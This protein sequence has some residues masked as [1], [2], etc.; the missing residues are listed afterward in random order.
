MGL[1]TLYVLCDDFLKEYQL[2][3]EAEGVVYVELLPK[4]ENRTS[5][6]LPVEA[7]FGKWIIRSRSDLGLKVNGR[8]V[9][10]Q[11]LAGQDVVTVVLP[12]GKVVLYVEQGNNGALSFQKFD[13]SNAQQISIGA[14]ER[15]TIVYNPP[16]ISS[17]HAVMKIDSGKASISVPDHQNLLYVNGI[18]TQSAA[19]NFGDM[20]CIMGLKIVYLGF[21]LA[22]NTPHGFEKCRLDPYD[23]TNAQKHMDEQSSRFGIMDDTYFQ[24]SPRIIKRLEEGEVEI[25]SPPSPNTHKEQPFLLTIGPAMTMGMVSVFSVMFAFYTSKGNPQMVIPGLVMAGAMLTGA[26]VWPFLSRAYQKMTSKKEEKRRVKKYRQYIEKEYAKLEERIER[27]KKALSSTYPE[28][29]VCINRALNKDRR[30]WE[31]MPS[32]K[33]FLEMRLGKGVR[34]SSINVIIPREH[35]SMVD[36]PLIDELKNINNG[37]LTV[38]NVPICISMLENSMIGMIG[39]R[40]ILLDLVMSMLVQIAALHSYDEVKVV[41]IYKQSESST[42]EWVKQL[43]HVWGPD[44]AIRFTASCRDEAREVLLYLNEILKEREGTKGDLSSSPVLS[45]PHFI[46]FIADPE[47]VENEPVMRYLTSSNGVLGVSTVFVYEKINLLPKE[48]NAF[49]QC[50][51]SE[52]SLYHRDNPEGGMIVFKEDSVVGQDLDAFS[53]ALAGIK[54]KEIASAL[55]LP[56]M[57]TFLGMYKVGRIEHLEIKRRWRENMSYRSLEAPLGIKAGDMTFYLNIHEKYHGP[58]GLVAGMTGSGKSEFIQSYILS[59]AVN[60]H[61]YDVA[62]ILIDYKGGGMANCFEGLPHVAGTITN[63][64]GSQIRRSLVSLESELKRRQRI[65]AEHGVNHIDKYQQLYKEHKAEEPLPHL[66]II[67]DE[68]AELK[69]QQ[70]EFMQELVSAARIG[71]SLGVHLVLATQKPSGVVDDQ[72]WSNTRFRICLKVLDKNDSNEMIK[73][74]DAANIIQAGRCYVQVGNDE[75]FELVQS[76]WSGA[77]YV[78]TDKVENESAKQVMLIDGCARALKTVSCKSAVSKSEVSELSA[79][80]NY[81]SELARKDSIKTL[82]LWLE[83]L[84]ETIYLDEVENRKGGWNGNDWEESDHWLCPTLG[85]LDNPKNQTQFPLVINIGNDGHIAL[86]GAPGTGKTTFIQTLVYSLVTRYSPE[87]VN[88]YI[89]DF[90]GRTMGYFHELPHVGGIVFSDDAD[91]MDKLFKL[92]TKELENRKKMFAEYGVGTLKSYMEATGNKLPAMVMILDNYAAFNEL[93]PDYESLIVTLSREA[94]NYGI[95]MVL[96]GSNSN[97]IKYRVTQNFKLIFTLQLN[98]KYDYVTVVGQTNGLEPESVPGRGLIKV[99]TPLEFQTALACHAANEAERF[100]ELRKLF[101]E[102]NEKWKGHKAKQIPFIPNEVTRESMMG[103]DEVKQE[104]EKGLIPIGYDINE[105]EML[106]LDLQSNFV[107]SVLGSEQTGKTNFI[108]L[109][110]GFIKPTLDWKVYVI[111][112]P[113][114]ELQRVSLRMGADGYICDAEGFDGFITGLVD[115]MKMRHKDLKAFRENGVNPS[116]EYEYMQKY[117]SIVVLIDEFDSFYDMIS[118]EA[119]KYTESLLK[120]GS[121][122]EVSFIFT[123]N[124]QKI[125]RF[126]GSVLYTQVFKGLNGILLGGMM[127]SQNIFNVTMNYQ[128]RSERLDTGMG[129][130]INRNTYKTIKTPLA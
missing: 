111:D 25:D 4:T 45:L 31:R 89:L 129:Y 52:C 83:P 87:L 122:L 26:I 118:D 61:P 21:L 3:Q 41:C 120:G 99:G 116:K 105:A 69:S 117:Q 44:K 81:L 109:L 67:S 32:N 72:I 33:D 91:K 97:S 48:C 14:S 8:E 10:D 94:G 123:A 2:P 80:V 103:T 15:D 56:S 113:D 18:R 76:G 78:P 66:I 93:Y 108:K 104:L 115:E 77:P 74:P 130:L 84:K 37:Y 7:M 114:G 79:V 95:Y 57:L 82:K 102:M 127:D 1:I 88:I 51:D 101:K 125:S 49:I 34:P 28:P 128:Q 53:R 70:P 23:R 60:Y 12:E 126:T 36:D 98:D 90:G 92:L 85:L 106:S 13:C 65:F 64:G 54:V 17:N 55:S 38:P 110:L 121:G 22:V 86:F 68:F 43:P 73:K 11:E 100:F 124:P 20:I 119:L 40:K 6:V 24:R 58:H 46:V 75:I 30:L 59:M 35:F 9:E 96:T 62:F 42:W 29:T 5:C 16:L 112:K 63:L 71:R 27:N 39:D 19:L 47:L 107:Y 50:A